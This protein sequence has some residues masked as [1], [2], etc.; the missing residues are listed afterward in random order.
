MMCSLL[1]STTSRRSKGVS[2]GSSRH[3]SGVQGDLPE[4]PSVCRIRSKSPSSLCRSSGARL[5]STRPVSARSSSAATINRPPRPLRDHGLHSASHHRAGRPI[6]F[7]K[8]IGITSA[9][10]VFLQEAADT[11]DGEATAQQ[12]LS[13]TFTMAFDVTTT[14]AC[15][16]WWRVSRWQTQA[17]WH[18]RSRP[19]AARQRQL[20]LSNSRLDLPTFGT[21][22]QR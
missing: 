8:I 20:A 11:P 19:N 1:A 18:I 6:Q 5:P 16:S 4:S 15:R 10:A 13:F 2:R 17:G 21:A 22:R 14:S 12:H 3:T 9:G 7:S